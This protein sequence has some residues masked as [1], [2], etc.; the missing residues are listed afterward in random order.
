MINETIA[1][2]KALQVE[3]NKTN[4]WMLKKYMDAFFSGELKRGEFQDPLTEELG[5]LRTFIEC[6]KNHDGKLARQ[7][8]LAVLSAAHYRMAQNY[9]RS[10]KC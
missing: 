2:M 4:H 8:E 5:T 1:H 10:S 3:L 9:L 6:A 7:I